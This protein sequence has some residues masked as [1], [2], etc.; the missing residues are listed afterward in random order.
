M[1]TLTL[2]AAVGWVVCGVL[3]YGINVAY[4]QRK[5][6]SIAAEKYRED[7]AMAV[8]IAA[9]GPI[10]LWISYFLSGFAEHGLMYRRPRGER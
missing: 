1:T 7:C 4:F 8:L 5:F 2:A 3:A 10:A 9:A 6:P